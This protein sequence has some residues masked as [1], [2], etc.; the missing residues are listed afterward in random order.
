M[1]MQLINHWLVFSNVFFLI[2]LL[3]YSTYIL[4]ANLFGSIRLYR[5]RRM[6]QLHNELKDSYYYPMS[7]IVPAY[8]ESVSIVQNLRNLLKLDYRLY[9]IIVVDDGSTDDTR[10]ILLDYFDFTPDPERPIRY[11][12]PCKPIHEVWTT[13]AN[14]IPIT[15]VCKENGKCKADAVNA[16]INLVS[17]PYFVCM[18][19]DEVLQKDALIYAAKAIMSKGEVIAVGGN[20]KISNSVTFRDAMPA[21][22]KLGENL[23]VDMQVLEYSRAFV[24]ARIFH[25]ITN[26]NL[27]ISGGFGIFRTSSVVAVGGYDSTSMGE[28]M[29][30]TVKLH[31]YYRRNQLPYH[32][33]YVPDSVCWT[34]APA[35]FKDLRKQ[36]ERWHCGLIQNI[37][38]YRNM[39]FNPRYGLVGVFMIPF[40][41]FFEL[42]ASFFIIIGWLNILLSIM[43]HQI[44]LPYVLY[45]MAA[46]MM[47][48]IVMTVT[49]FI[50]KMNMRH[51]FFS[52][53]DIVKA[54]G[55]A[56][57][58]SVLIRPWLFLVEFSAFF[59]Y[60]RLK[61]RWESPKRVKVKEI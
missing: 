36:R 10:Q 33:E 50:D 16:A 53:L 58:D 60:S 29:E 9:E 4:I 44:N 32:M 15:L 20:V 12:V 54:F 14:G 56:F 40:M 45:V 19:A 59:K 7:I 42:F 17:Y 57:L 55:I 18:D 49:V 21:F 26:T 48:G 11:R 35:S 25:N 13:N 27:I 6:E 2:Y 46:Y 37:W 47:L 51:D 3:V 30:L 43:T 22:A 28:D 31:E 5:N 52:G 61:G 23:L 41:I 24:G 8:N 39:A 38:K 34:Q 1:L